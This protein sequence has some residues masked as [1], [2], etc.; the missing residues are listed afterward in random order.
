MRSQFF[1][2]LVVM[3][4][5]AAPALAEDTI[6]IKTR[7]GVTME[8]LYQKAENP[9]AHLILLE[10]GGGEF[11]D[12]RNPLFLVGTRDEFGD[13]EFSV[14]AVNP[15]S[16]TGGDMRRGFRWSAEHVEDID[17]LTRWLKKQ[18]NV[19]V[20]L[21][22]VSLGS[23]SV[24]WVGGHAKEK[25]GG[26]VFI[27][28]KT[29]GKGRSVME[30]GLDK[31]RIPAL[32]VHHEGDE[33]GLPASEGTKAIKEGLT[34]S[35]KVEIKMFSGGSNSGRRACGPG[36]YHTFHGIQSKVADAISQ[37]IKAQTK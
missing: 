21:L 25:L 4:V 10:G 18:K 17:A 5:A 9:P 33:C 8:I 16:D 37:F 36:T 23:Q 26:V 32:I 2:A 30:L 14:A 22:G 31:I 28:S 24:A 13:N 6:E 34:N 19:P 15:P 12:L 1:S 7:P 27:A 35:P 20:W 29:A 11:K 3:F